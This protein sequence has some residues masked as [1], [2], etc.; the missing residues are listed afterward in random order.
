MARLFLERGGEAERVKRLIND[1][2]RALN[3]QDRNDGR[4]RLTGTAFLIYI[5]DPEYP[6]GR[7]RVLVWHGP[8]DGGPFYDEAILQKASLHSVDFV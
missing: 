8:S 7:E 5:L 6:Q 3:G 1:I 4:V 2:I